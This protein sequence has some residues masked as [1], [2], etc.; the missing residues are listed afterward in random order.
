M[1]IEGKTPKVI[2]AI[3]TRHSSDQSAGNNIY[4]FIDPFAVCNV[5]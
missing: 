3:N 2:S 1:C 5:A 4:R